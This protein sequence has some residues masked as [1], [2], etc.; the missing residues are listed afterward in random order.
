M[1]ETCG[2]TGGETNAEASSYY[3]TEPFCTDRNRCAPVQNAIARAAQWQ[4]DKAFSVRDKKQNPKK[5]N[6]KS[7]TKKA[8]PKKQNQKCRTKNAEPKIYRTKNLQ[9]Q[10]M[11]NSKKQERK[12][13]NVQTGFSKRKHGRT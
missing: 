9:N 13:D 2:V 10:E 11:Q 12:R 7:R 3:G 4:Q 8:E 5:Q 6:Q 1:S